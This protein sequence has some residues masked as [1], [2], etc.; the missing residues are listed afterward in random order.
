LLVL[1]F[2][3]KE[4]FMK[5][6]PF[7]P[8]RAAAAL[9]VVGLALAAGNALAVDL[10][11]TKLTGLTGDV[12]GPFTA[13]YRADLS[14]TGLASINQIIVTDTSGGSGGASGQYSGMDLDGVFISDTAV[15]DA[16]LVGGL[17]LAAVFDYSAAGTA[18]AA[19]TQRA[20]A[21]PDLYNVPGGAIDFAAASLGAMDAVGVIPG[22]GY[23]S[24]GDGGALTLNL[25]SAI[26]PSVHRYLYVGEVGDNGETFTAAAVPEPSTVILAGLGG[27]ALAFGCRR[28]ARG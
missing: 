26:D 3:S 2:S 9:A 1:S 4:T 18:F 28:R 25:T 22:S 24:M 19:G 16:T 12:K 14:A 13:V 21:D 17:A 15:D 10:L 8:L 23:F 6:S 5:A 7:Q 11:F 20:P 27:L